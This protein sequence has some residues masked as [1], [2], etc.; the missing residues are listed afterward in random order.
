MP[1]LL[2]TQSTP[3]VA[4]PQTG[5][6]AQILRAGPRFYAC[7]AL[8]LAAGVLLQAAGK[9]AGRYFRKEAVPLKRS[10]ALMDKDKLLPE[11]RWDTRPI[12]PLS[13]DILQ[14]LG[15]S[16]YLNWRILNPLLKPTDSTY[17]AS[18]FITYYTG[19]P[20]MVP[21]VPDQCYVAGGFAPV[22]APKTERV[23]V[24]GVGAPGDQMPVRVSCFEGQRPRAGEFFAGGNPKTVLYFFYINGRYATTRDE[25][26]V[27]LSN[28]LD[29]YAYYAKIELSFTDYTGQINA[30]REEALAAVGPLMEKALPI[31]LQDHLQDWQT[32]TAAAP[33]QAR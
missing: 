21:H 20:D 2:E 4:A 22:G 6:L 15:T 7:V 8:L 16:E 13:E 24:R 31:L 12:E 1:T 29:K 28:P 23:P 11:Y 14:T 25:A 9:L 27:I 10:L 26:R 32:L 5:L 3:S 18:L 30:G 17:M 33:P 19:K